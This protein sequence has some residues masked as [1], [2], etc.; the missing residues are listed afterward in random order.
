MLICNKAKGVASYQLFLQNSVQVHFL[1]AQCHFALVFEF[2]D[3]SLEKGHRLFL[4]PTG[5]SLAGPPR[6]LY[7]RRLPISKLI[8]RHLKCVGLTS[9]TIKKH[10]VIGIK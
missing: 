9:C 4:A 6:S 1:R 7:R 3:F 2:S 10:S 5:A 8:L